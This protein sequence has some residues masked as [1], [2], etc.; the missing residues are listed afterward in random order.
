MKFVKCESHGCNLVKIFFVKKII[1][2]IKFIKVSYAKGKKNGKK[3]LKSGEEETTWE[4]RQVKRIACYLCF[5]EEGTRNFWGNKT[6]I[7][8][9]SPKS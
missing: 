5:R 3:R 1:H 4:C 7:Y 8:S 6:K 2:N 9:N